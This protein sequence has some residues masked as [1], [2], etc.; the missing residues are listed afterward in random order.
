MGK[1]QTLKKLFRLLSQSRAHVYTAENACHSYCLVHNLEIILSTDH[2]EGGRAVSDWSLHLETTE[3]IPTPK[4]W[5]PAEQRAR[6][7]SSRVILLQPQCNPLMA[8]INCYSCSLKPDLSCLSTACYLSD[9]NVLLSF[10]VASIF[11]LQHLPSTKTDLS[12]KTLH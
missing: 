1:L 10:K 6:M 11:F 2:D 9:R 5:H 7:I 12:V 8:Q 4:H 3:Q